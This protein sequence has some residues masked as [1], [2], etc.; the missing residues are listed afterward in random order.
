MSDLP[1]GFSMP[2]DP[3]DESGRRSGN[4]GSG[5]GNGGP[6]GDLPNVPGGFPFGD[7]QQM[8]QM[9][10]QFADMM[11][12][13]SA[14]G[15]SGASGTINWDMARNIARHLVS[16]QGDPSVSAHEYAQVQEALRLADLWVNEGAS[17]PSGVHTMEAWS[18]SEWIEKTMDSWS[19]LCE[20]L[21]S[22]I[23]ESMGQNLPG[24]M[25]SM[26]GP[27]LGMV[28]QM[29]GMLVGQQAGQAI[30]ELSREVVGSTDVGVPLAGDGR[31][32]L[33][34]PGVSAFGEGLG[35]P[36][37][38]VR[39]YLAARE[40]AHHRL[41]GHV[42]WLR[43]HVFT[44]VEEYARGMSFD[45][46]ALE[47]KLGRI[48]I[49]NPEALQEALS[50]SEGQGLFQ[51]QDTPQQK[52]SLARL[53]TTLALVEGWVSVVVDASVAG[54]LPHAAAL[55]EAAR[56]RRASGGPAEHT[57]ATLVG[58][59]LRPRRLREAATLW[60]ALGEARGVEGRDAVWQHPDLMPSSADLDDPG[61]FVSG[62]TGDEAADID[63]S[64]F[65]DDT[66]PEG[67]DGADGP[68]R[69]DGGR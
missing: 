46:S 59:E 44:L 57:F 33:L 21:T 7:P 28:R 63:I 34:P 2:N 14:P 60:T 32:A 13:Q 62:Q 19:R 36:L 39:L 15:S 38:E 8:A 58:L 22:R 43:S 47:E 29:G 64:Q 5:S 55:A 67:D 68:E 18:R 66:K 30:G 42:P 6:G 45:M 12:A 65:T 9:L 25:Q 49:S 10:R 4:S 50:G 61:P 20:P 51:P 35:I 40:V 56:R 27:L 23:V 11:A 31:A 17:L 1:F 3:D 52:A 24:E 53:E 48:D 41:F 37:D 16:E 54:R 26:A 69:P